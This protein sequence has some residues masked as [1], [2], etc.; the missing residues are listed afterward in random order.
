MRVGLKVCVGG[1]AQEGGH[2]AEAI[3]N[4]RFDRGIIVAISTRPS[5]QKII[6]NPKRSH[7]RVHNDNDIFIV[8]AD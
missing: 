4:S 5:R 7:S 2:A 8:N 3:L 6:W 1:V